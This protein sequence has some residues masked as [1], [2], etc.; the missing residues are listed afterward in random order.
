MSTSRYTPEKRHG[1]SAQQGTLQDEKGSIIDSNRIIDARSTDT[2][3]SYIVIVFARYKRDLLTILVD[4]ENNK[5]DSVSAWDWTSNFG[6]ILT[7]RALHKC[8]YIMH[9]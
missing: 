4:L 9:G 1:A 7:S 3:S 8:I 5:N 6:F 2:S